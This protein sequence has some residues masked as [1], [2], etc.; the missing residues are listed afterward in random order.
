MQY[1]P[2]PWNQ[3]LPVLPRVVFVDWYGVLSTTRYWASVKD[4]PLVAE[5]IDLGRARHRIFDTEV[6]ND[7][8]RGHLSTRD[9]V[10]RFLVDHDNP[11]LVAFLEQQAIDDCTQGPIR[12]QVVHQLRKLRARHLVVLATD[13]MDCFT[14]AL[15]HR[16]DLRTVFDDYLTSCELGVLKAED[17]ERFFLPW[18]DAH[19]ITANNAVLVDD[20]AENCARFCELGGQAIVFDNSAPTWTALRSLVAV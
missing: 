8:M 5:S 19:R 11:E 1:R 15:P 6:V 2:S 3:I 4:H 10:A 20:R 17:P 14:A 7:W 9:V 12:R 16:Q 18:L 13:N